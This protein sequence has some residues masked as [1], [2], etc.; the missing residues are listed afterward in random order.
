MRSTIFCNHYRA[1]HGN[2]TCK[3]GV[4]FD[5]FKG[6]AFD[7]RPCFC[8]PGA[9]PNPGCSLQEMPTPE[10][11][12]AEEAEMNARFEKIGKARKAI[13]ENLG[14]PWK[15]GKPSVAGVID[16]PACG[17]EQSLQFSCSGYNGHVHAKCKT[18]GCVSWME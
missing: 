4:A 6:G 2:T 17:K 1:M 9:T 7:Q 11:L 14:G 3:V 8:N 12:A 13:V 10:Q 16:C 15:R 18:E 5:D